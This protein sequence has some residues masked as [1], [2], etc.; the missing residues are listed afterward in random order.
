[1][2][3]VFTSRRLLGNLFLFGSRPVSEAQEGIPPPRTCRSNT[4]PTSS[5]PQFTSGLCGEPADALSPVYARCL[6]LHCRDRLRDR[7]SWTA[8]EPPD[9][10]VGVSDCT[11]RDSTRRRSPSPR[12]NQQSHC[13]RRRCTLV[14][15]RREERSRMLPCHRLCP[16]RT[17]RTSDCMLPGL[18][19]PPQTA[20]LL[21]PSALRGPDAR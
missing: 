1:V 14:C 16:C 19:E 5:H 9:A 6:D 12:Q 13:L 21:H 3:W 10:L 8:Y 4:T 17:D 18:T 20:C 11:S 7:L 15:D 2:V